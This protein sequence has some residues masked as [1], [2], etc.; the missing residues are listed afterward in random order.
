LACRKRRKFR[1]ISLTLEIG[2]KQWNGIII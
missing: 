1:R 2:Q